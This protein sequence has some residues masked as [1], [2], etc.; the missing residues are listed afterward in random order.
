MATD[1]LTQRRRGRSVKKRLCYAA[2]PTILAL[3]LV[4]GSFRVY[5]LLGTEAWSR[6]RYETVASR[7]AC[8][9]KPWFTREFMASWCRVHLVPRYNPPGTGIVVTSDYSDP[10]YTIQNG[11][12]ATVGFNSKALSPG[13]RHRRVFLLGGSTTICLDVPDRYTYASQLQERLT[14]LAVTK[15]IEVV[16]CG[17]PAVVSGEEFERLKYEIGRNNIPDFCIF[18]DGVNDVLEGVFNG[19]PGRSIHTEGVEYAQSRLLVPSGE[20]AG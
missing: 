9:S 8:A 7:P 13:H 12:R 5:A 1:I 6:N 19:H 20:C 17:V 18:F 10:F 3:L 15:D 2:I 16:N 4:E 14:A 11:I